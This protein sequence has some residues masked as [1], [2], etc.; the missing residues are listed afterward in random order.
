MALFFM[1]VENLPGDIPRRGYNTPCPLWC[2]DDF[3]TEEFLLDMREQDFEDQEEINGGRIVTDSR[4]VDSKE[5]IFDAPPS[6]IIGQYEEQPSFPCPE[7]LRLDNPV[8]LVPV[9]DGPVINYSYP[10][11][12]YV[13]I[14]LLNG[15]LDVLTQPN[16]ICGGNTIFRLAAEEIINTRSYWEVHLGDAC[17]VSEVVRITPRIQWESNQFSC[18]TAAISVD[19]CEHKLNLRFEIE[20]DTSPLNDS[21]ARWTTGTE[22]ESTILSLSIDDAN[23]HQPQGGYTASPIAK[24]FYLSSLIQSFHEDQRFRLSFS[25]EP[26][27]VEFVYL[28]VIPGFRTLLE[29]ADDLNMLG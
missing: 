9:E 23:W 20:N 27:F 24:R 26:M 14:S 29:I 8:D 21:I 18:I 2:E 25:D 6:E 28:K 15:Q 19:P 4:L 10:W 22:A 12:M 1:P 16:N 13:K 5:W 3:Q 7:F 17:G 11:T